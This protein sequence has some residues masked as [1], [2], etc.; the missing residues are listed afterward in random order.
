MNKEVKEYDKNSNLIYYKNNGLEFWYKYD[1]N[2]NC[3]HCKD[4][5]GYEY[6]REYDENNNCIHY[7]NNEGDEYFYKW[8]DEEKIKITKQEFEQIKIINNF[9]LNN[10]K[11]SRLELMDL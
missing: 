6:W 3:I 11:I 2:N 1:E 7:K 8:L 5:N 4:Y 10:S 9:Y